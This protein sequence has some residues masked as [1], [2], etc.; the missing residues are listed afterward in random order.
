MQAQTRWFIR[1]SRSVIDGEYLILILFLACYMSN[2]LLVG[3]PS[4][5]R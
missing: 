5:V 4:S 3:V 2:G 1:V